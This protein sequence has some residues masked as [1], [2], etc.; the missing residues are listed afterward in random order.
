MKRLEEGLYEFETELHKKVKVDVNKQIIYGVKGTA[1]KTIPTYTMINKIEQVLFEYSYNNSS[2]FYLLEKLAN[3]SNAYPALCNILQDSGSLY[4]NCGL[5]SSIK[6]LKNFAKAYNNYMNDDTID[7]KIGWIKFINMYNYTVEKNLTIAEG[8]ILWRVYDFSDSLSY[9]INRYRFSNH[10]LLTPC[11][12][13]TLKTTEL[14]WIIKFYYTLKEQNLANIS[15]FFNVDR[16]CYWEIIRA[17]LLECIIYCRTLNTSLPT[18]KDIYSIWHNLSEQTRQHI[19]KKEAELKEEEAKLFMKRQTEYDLHYE[20]EYFTV[21]VP[22]SWEECA[23][24]G[25]A[26]HNCLGGYEWENYLRNGNRGVVF[27]RKKDCP[28]KP[29]IACDFNWDTK[30]ISQFLTYY[31]DDVTD[32]KAL[33]FKSAFQ[34]YLYNLQQFVSLLGVAEM[35]HS[36]FCVRRVAARRFLDNY[37][38]CAY[39]SINLRCCATLPKV[40]KRD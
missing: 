33:A 9:G 10:I 13:E 5:L 30:W 8:H 24:E 25:S 39:F 21:V 23:D 14:K 4:Y 20:N 22:T 28:D 36:F 12:R 32:G 37:I 3:M 31:N 26:L 7:A 11:T 15:E 19:A 1:L 6:S 35:P 17:R 16:D 34:T 18:G 29:Y 2:K 27:I 38:S 40:P